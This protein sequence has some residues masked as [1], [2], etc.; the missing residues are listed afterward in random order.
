MEWNEIVRENA[1]KLT[2]DMKKEKF[3]IK[4]RAYRQGLLSEEEVD[5]LWIEFLQDEELYKQWLMEENL[6]RYFQQ[7]KAKIAEGTDVADGASVVSGPS[8]GMVMGGSEGTGGF[9]GTG[10]S[11]GTGGSERSVVPVRRIFPLAVASAAVVVFALL[12]QV[13]QLGQNTM[14]DVSYLAVESLSVDYM[15]SGVVYRSGSDTEAGSGSVAGDEDSTDVPSISVDQE[16]ELS[17]LMAMRGDYNTAESILD[18]IVDPSA[19]A[20][21]ISDRQRAVVLYNLGIAKYN[22]GKFEESLSAFQTA[23]Q[24]QATSSSPLLSDNQMV[25]LHWFQANAHLKLNR[26]LQ[27]TA[28][29]T[30]LADGEGAIARQSS[31]ILDRLMQTHTE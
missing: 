30:Y 31:A 1:R 13:F 27:A 9:E 25:L 28:H 29:L 3:D 26:P 19:E 15:I 21:A 4:I 6:Y 14:E 5:Q 22:T 23:Q 8:E 7:R 18:R 10:S 17:I 24:S 2:R 16:I 11:K 20:R 12:L